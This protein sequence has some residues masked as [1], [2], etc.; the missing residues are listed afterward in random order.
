M[1][2]QNNKK[3]PF[4]SI[5]E[6]LDLYLSMLHPGGLP[7]G[8]EKEKIVVAIREK[9]ISER[10]EWAESSGIKQEQPP[11]KNYAELKGQI[12]QEAQKEELP[13][14]PEERYHYERR[15]EAKENREK[16]LAEENA[17][18][19]DA[20]I[21]KRLTEKNREENRE[22]IERALLIR[23]ALEKRAN[24]VLKHRKLETDVVES[25]PNQSK[26]DRPEFSE[27]TTSSQMAHES[28]QTNLSASSPLAFM[29][30][31]FNPEEESNSFDL[32][33]LDHSERLV[34]Q[35]RTNTADSQKFSDEFREQQKAKKREERNSLA[36]D[37]KKDTQEKQKGKHDINH[38]TMKVEDKI[39]YLQR[40]NENRRSMVKTR[41]EVL[42]MGGT[43]ERF[44]MNMNMGM[45]LDTSDKE[46]KKEKKSGGGFSL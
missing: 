42:K 40:Y 32:E 28:P 26:S 29:Q 12:V 24:D 6:A 35:E 34:E 20:E 33:S 16:K 36:R 10:P 11:P 14:D 9:I 8:E 44:S 19:S 18:E 39:D 30:E 38:A 27:E 46:T 1:G 3:P 25:K 4:V 45:K 22:T 5:D 31:R 13:E 43:D 21:R 7:E 17:A 15:K 37:L 23:K 41:S 2:E